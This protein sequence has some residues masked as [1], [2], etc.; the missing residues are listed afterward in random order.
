MDTGFPRYSNY[1]CGK[2]KIYPILV[3]SQTK[4]ANIGDIIHIL[5]HPF[6]VLKSPFGGV[7]A[8]IGTSGFDSAR[9]L[10]APTLNG[11]GMWIG[12]IYDEDL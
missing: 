6:C 10:F 12:S 4:I 11:Y 2:E 3:D 9:I 1:S 7:P 5:D 8:M